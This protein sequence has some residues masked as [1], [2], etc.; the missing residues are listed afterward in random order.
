[1]I[2]QNSFYFFSIFRFI[3]KELKSFSL[4][5]THFH[6]LTD[7][8]KQVSCI[9]NVHLKAMTSKDNLTMLYQVEDGICDQSYGVHV[10][11][12]AQFPQN[13]IEVCNINLIFN[14]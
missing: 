6:E 11:Q 9:G 13:V 7:L 10:A 8:S 1:M 2:I 12:L 5:A 14:C 3:A 4:F